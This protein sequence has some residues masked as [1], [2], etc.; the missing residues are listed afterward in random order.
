MQPDPP[1][2]DEDDALLNA[3]GGVYREREAEADAAWPA[4][5]PPFTAIDGAEANALFERVRSSAGPAAEASG[6]ATVLAFPKRRVLAAALAIA[7]GLLMF[8]LTRGPSGEDGLPPYELTALT[9][10]QA[11]RNDPRERPATQRAEYTPGSRV[12][13]VARPAAGIKGAVTARIYVRQAGEVVAVPTVPRVSA[14]GAVRV[15]LV[16]GETLPMQTGDGEVI[17]L[18]LP[19]GVSADEAIKAADPAPAQRLVH[20]FRYRP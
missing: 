1:S 19:A 18:V 2:P 10:D 14:K 7:A 4:A 12:L 13:L 11:V 9:G 5:E 15:D 6:D 20:R 3:L 16:A 17:L 8:V